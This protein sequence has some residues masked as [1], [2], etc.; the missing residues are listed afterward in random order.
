MNNPIKLNENK[1]IP[2]KTFSQVGESLNAEVNLEY[3]KPPRISLFLDSFT[4]DLIVQPIVADYFNEY[5]LSSFYENK[6]RYSA[7]FKYL[8]IGNAD[9]ENIK[10]VYFTVP[11]LSAYFHREL[12]YKLDDDVNISG[13]LRIEPLISRID[14]LGLSI[15][16]HQGYNL[17]SY[18]DNTGFSFKNII[19]FSYESDSKL[20]FLDIENYMYKTIA[21]LTW[22]TGYP[23]SVDSIEVSDGEKL[24]YLYLPLVKKLNTYDLSFPKSFMQLFLLRDNFQT[25]CNNFFEKKELFTDIWSRTL[26]LF[27]FTGVLE[28][29]VMLFTSILDKYFS[30][31]VK[32]HKDN[33]IENYESYLIKIGGFL[34]DNNQLKELLM[35]TKLLENIKLNELR[36]VFPENNIQSFLS[37]QKAYF[38]IFNSEDLKIFLFKNDFKTIISIRDNAAHG[39]REELTTEE[40]LKYSWKVKLLT[41]YLIYKDLG[42]KNDEFFKIISNTFHPIVLNCEMNEEL[43]D[44]KTGKSIYIKLSMIER[45]KMNSYNTRIKVFNKNDN[46]YLFDYLLSQKASNYFSQDI[47]YSFDPARFYSYEKYIQYLIDEEGLDKKAKHYSSV[48]LKNNDSK[49]LVNDVIIIY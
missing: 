11:E 30:S 29:E 17:K 47:N 13:N 28:Y 33:K 23:I 4:D 9:R 48:Y 16:I 38:K 5:C 37:K 40:V 10:K 20:S 12:N 46:V 32:N 25:I 1:T 26:P 6:S 3:G 42:V 34:K 41:M 49:V 43:L 8:Y 44:I 39:S 22:I 35:D 21:L 14:K 15:K 18:E 31:Q 27:D 24:G 36:K 45:D 2:V 7:L 19:Y